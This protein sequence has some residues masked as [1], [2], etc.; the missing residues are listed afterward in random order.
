MKKKLITLFAII[1]L[2]ALIVIP[3]TGCG[4]EPA[5]TE[6]PLVELQNDFDEL[7]AEFDSELVNIKT[8]LSH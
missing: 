6:N 5:E 8:R 1:A 7:S 4:G 3:L 2:M